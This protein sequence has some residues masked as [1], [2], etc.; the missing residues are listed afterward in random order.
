[1]DNDFNY[2]IINITILII[3]SW[4]EVIVRIKKTQ[5]KKKE[6]RKKLEEESLENMDQFAFRG[7]KQRGIAG[8]DV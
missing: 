6:I 2:A 5:K 7:L 8:E 4:Q 3:F 1:M